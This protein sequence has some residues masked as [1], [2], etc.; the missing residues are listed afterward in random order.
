MRRPR[1]SDSLQTQSKLVTVAERLFAERG[2]DGVS[3]SEI[4][5]AAEQGNNSALHYHFGSKDGLVSAIRD[6]HSERIDIAA[7]ESL[8]SLPESPSLRQTLA[9]MVDAFAARLD[10]P[11]GGP[12]YIRICAQAQANPNQASF[13]T[14][15]NEL[16]ESFTAFGR[17]I[18]DAAEDVPDLVR[19]Q[20]FYL[21]TATLFTALAAIV[22]D[23]EAGVID[24][25]SRPAL[26]S[27][28][29][30][31]LLGMLNAPVSAETAGLV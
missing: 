8:G 9:A 14:W 27:S 12:F 4:N 29:V 25:Q 2:V 18:R 7:A 24:P 1:R 16:P 30:D 26:V 19:E 10:D 11:D 13:R 17:P 3:L 28:L 5:R 20:R 31:T 22:V 21:L 6:K 15:M 23:E